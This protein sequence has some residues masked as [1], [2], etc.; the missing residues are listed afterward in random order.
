MPK[1]KKILIFET[2]N[3]F[4]TQINKET[5][6]KKTK[7]FFFNNKK[8][9]IL[10]NHIEEAHAI[11]NAPRKIFNENLL[12][13]AKK[14]EWVHSGG[15]GIETFLFNKFV[16]SKCLFTNGKILQGPS[17]SEHAIA[18]LLALSR[19][20][21]FT[22]K[23]KKSYD[24]RRPLELKGKIC[25]V[26]GLGGIGA[27]IAEKLNSFGMKIVGYNDEMVPL[28]HV[29]QNIFLYKNLPETVNKLDVLISSAPLTLKTKKIFSKKIF[30][31]MKNESIF[32]NISRGGLVDT[33]AF[34]DKKISSKFR[35]IGL[36]VTDPEPLPRN[37]F[38]Q[39]LDN[40]ILSNHTAGPSDQNRQ[41]SLDLMIENLKRFSNQDQLL[42]IVDKK[43]GY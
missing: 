29:Y 2:N 3:N 28:S 20:L 22:L 40:V 24:E 17:V 11:I 5:N 33:D 4:I 27:L 21:H 6:K 16:N 9:E 39:K 12:Y 41:R 10:N 26:F 13:K 25:G 18:L 23:N 31:K 43:K 30:K 8:L 34:R 42:N 7:I 1:M 38:L 14:L 35:G 15:A 36:D 32:I 19:N 37:H